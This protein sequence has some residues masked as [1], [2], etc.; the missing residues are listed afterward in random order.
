M[1]ACLEGLLSSIKG[2]DLSHLCYLAVVLVDGFEIGSQER[3]IPDVAVVHRKLYPSLATETV[4][5]LRPFT[6]EQ[7]RTLYYN[8]ELEHVDEFVDAFLQVNAQREIGI[9][10]YKSHSLA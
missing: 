4:E 9:L 2:V 6:D 1:Q 7:L 5:P 8:H 3:R 10:L